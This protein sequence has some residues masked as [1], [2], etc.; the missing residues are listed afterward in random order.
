MTTPNA[1]PPVSTTRLTF[2]DDFSTFSASASGAGTTWQDQLPYGGEAAH[3]LAGNSEAEYYSSDLSGSNSPFSDQNGTLNISAFPA[4]AGSNPYGLPYTSGAMTTAQ[5][6]SQTYGYFAV[7]AKLPSG[8]GLWPAFWML[9]TAGYTAELDDFEVINNQVT[10]DFATTHGTT[11][12]QWVVDSQALGAP[13]L[14]AGFNVFG[15]DWEPTT[16]TFYINGQA[17]GSAPTPQSMSSP[18]Y[19]LLNLAVGGNGSWPGSPNSSTNFPATMQINWV[20]AYAT[21][22]TT[23]VGGSAALS[24]AA[25]VAS[26]P[27]PAASTASP[28]PV[29][30]SSSNS[31]APAAATPSP[32]TVGSGPDQLTLQI[33][34]D[35]YQGDAQFTI[36]VDGVQQGGVQTT[37]AIQNAGQ[38]QAFSV[39][40]SFGTTNHTVSV[41]FLNDAYGGSASTDRNL[42]VDSAAI[43]GSAVPNASLQEDVAGSQ[44]LSFTG[45]DTASQ[46]VASTA[47]PATASGTDTL[48]IGLTEDAYQGD[49]QASISIDGTTL[50]S[51]TVT[52]LNSA[53]TAELFTYTGDFGGAGV[54]HNVAVSFLNDAYAGSP[55]LDRN[56]YV[57]SVNLDGI[58]APNDQAALYNA[59]T[60]N[61]A[62]PPATTLIPNTQNS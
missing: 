32:V 24:A 30:A 55:S 57:Q 19:M 58:A 45:N 29:T 3:T 10:T 28:A 25:A 48:T 18:M 15:V 50:G 23:Y 16:T 11:N 40:G 49:A 5:S 52:F 35:Q 51:P 61:F 47:A 36:S 1:N 26:T 41:N 9:P 27:Q 56:L 39:D 42:Y 14:S 60:T 4:A 34:E 22:N 2:Q 62:I 17:I 6:F 21:A 31:P 46:S 8:Q 37:T 44:S 33:A 7:D 59:G 43:N 54:S 38:T 20:Q 12:G 53:G 13:N